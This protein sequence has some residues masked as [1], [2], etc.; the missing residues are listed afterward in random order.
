MNLRRL[1]LN[2]LVALDALLS[3]RHVTRAAMRIGLSQ[4]AMS[5][6]LRRLRD[7][8][9]DELLIRTPVGMEPTPRALELVQPIRQILRQAE[10]ILEAP[11]RFD[12]AT[13]SHRLRIRMSDV[14]GYLLLPGLMARIRRQAPGVSLE[15]VHLPP[16]DTVAAL[17]TD[18]IDLAVSMDLELSSSVRGSALLEDRMVCVMSERHPLAHKR[19]TLPAFL[20]QHHIKVSISPLDGRYVDGALAKMGT[21]RKVAL[22]VPHWLLVP[23]LLSDS[24]MVSVLSER[25]AKLVGAGLVLHGLPFP[26]T[27]FNWSLYWHRR[28]D[29]T[30]VHCW[31]R[32]ML[33][34]TARDLAADS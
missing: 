30:P 14:L 21:S 28:Y 23:R 22:N 13:A 5:N 20:A 2:L 6:T 4:P 17:E 27:D 16:V 29:A 10:R 26:G 9:K 32:E 24:S 12:P 7:V 19:L 33:N 15:V 3:E 1:D 8:M 11:E 25:Y 34:E 18:A 31:L